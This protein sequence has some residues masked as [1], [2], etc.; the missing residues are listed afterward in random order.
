M[1]GIRWHHL[2]REHGVENGFDALMQELMRRARERTTGR[3]EGDVGGE[4]PHG[5]RRDPGAIGHDAGIT[6]SGL[7]PMLAIHVR[8]NFMRVRLRYAG[9]EP[10]IRELKRVARHRVVIL[11]WDPA[12]PGFWLTD[13][14]PEIL[15]ID[16]RIF[17]ELG[18]LN[19]LL[20]ETCPRAILI[21]HDC[22]DG[23]LGAYWRRPGAYLDAGVRSSISTF[24]KLTNVATG[25]AQPGQVP[26]S[27]NHPA[28]IWKRPGTASVRR[29][30]VA[31]MLLPGGVETSGVVILVP[32]AT[33]SVVTAPANEPVETSSHAMLDGIV[34]STRPRQSVSRRRGRMTHRRCWPHRGS[35]AGCSRRPPAWSTTSSRSWSRTRAS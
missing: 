30:P 13:Y 2:A 19:R 22:T 4:E 9:G 3:G 35:S 34:I 29:R 7:K 18:E 15:E 6:G 21:P 33:L 1:L 11:T 17:P 16:R 31:M 26:T 12:S 14:F 8:Q 27:G 28:W 20:G 24:S 10:V 32:P 5:L 25:L 23:F